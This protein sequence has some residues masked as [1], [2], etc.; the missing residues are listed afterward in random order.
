MPGPVPKDPVLRQRRNRV[1]TRASLAPDGAPAEGHREIPALPKRHK[2]HKLTLA[3]WQDVWQS[4]MAPEYLQ[5]DIH[6]LYL[7]AEL[8]NRF[9]RKP[10]IPLAV[11]IRLQRQCFGLS[12]IDRRRLQWE[13]ERVE[14]T[15]RKQRVQA[16]PVEIDDPRRLLT[17]VS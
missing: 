17:V 8:V 10:S 9:W 3:W 1:A 16:P 15:T 14:A 4:P 13:V 12:P 2:W 5:A 11:E 7:L 6:G